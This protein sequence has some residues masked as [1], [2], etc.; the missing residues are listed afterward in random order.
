MPVPENDLVTET[1]RGCSKCNHKTLL[2]MSPVKLEKATNAVLRWHWA[3]VIDS[4]DAV[5]L[6]LKCHRYVTKHMLVTQ[7]GF[8]EQTVYEAKFTH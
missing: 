1:L 5:I 6:L 7:G 4:K 2:L 3:S 8:P